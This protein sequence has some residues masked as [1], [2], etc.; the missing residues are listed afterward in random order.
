M[1][2][3]AHQDP[4]SLRP[5]QQSLHS[6]PYQVQVQ[7]PNKDEAEHQKCDP[8]PPHARSEEQEV[9]QNPTGS[10]RAS[11]FHQDLDQTEHH[12]HT[13]PDQ[14]QTP[15]NQEAGGSVPALVITQAEE[16]LRQ[17]PAAPPPSCSSDGGDMACSDLLSLTSDSF[18]L[19]SEPAASRTSEEDD[20]RSVT[21]SSVLSL[22]HR[23]P[24]D[25][26]EK[27]WW[28]S[29]ALGNMAAQ[30]QL[31]LQDPGLVL[32]KTALHWAAKHG[33]QEAVDMMLRSGAD[34][35]VRSHGYT[36][37]HLASIHGH[38]HI[39]HTLITTHN[40]KTSVRD[41][42]GKTAVH[43]WRGCREVFNKPQPQP[44]GSSFVG[45]RTQRYALPSLL[46]TRSRSQ[47]QLDLGFG[48]PTL[49]ATHDALDL[50]V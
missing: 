24:L 27:H 1:N 46:L 25:P 16:S 9:D 33:R 23:V 19:T 50:H 8:D 10:G 3:D 38:Q 2:L 7:S 15:A 26:L 42:H 40:A 49:S 29:S 43:Y 18:S 4:E 37:L 32:K 39:V 17:T 48:P 20:S 6:S 47:G 30:R 14:G 41:Y 34:V 44:G 12:G 31:L 45:R 28:R 22:F 5:E 36:A 21:T 11:V 35:N 13:G